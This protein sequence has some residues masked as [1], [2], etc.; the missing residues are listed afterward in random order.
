MFIR[1]DNKPT[2]RGADTSSMRSHNSRLLLKMLWRAGELS[3]ADLARGSG[4]SRSTVSAIVAEL[5][6]AGIVSES[7]VARSQGG[8]P[9][10]VL[11]IEA[12]RFFI[13]GLELGAS[14]ITALRVDLRGRVRHQASVS[15]DVEQD[16]DGAQA[17]LLQLTDEMVASAGEAA[18]VGIGL[19]VPCPVDPRRP[20]LLSPRIL[21]KWTDV[22]LGALLHHRYSAPVLVD[23]DANLGA[24]A[25]RWWGAGQ[26]SDDFSYVKV[27]TG[28]GAGHI[29]DGHVYR[30]AFGIA[31]EI[32]HTAIDPNGPSCRCGRSGCLETMIGSA[33]LVAR[34][35]ARVAAGEPSSLARAPITMDALLAAAREG[36]PL[37]ADIVGRAGHFLGIA[38]ANLV[39]LLNPSLI[40]LGGHLTEAG[41][42]VLDPLHRVLAERVL[43]SSMEVAAVEISTMGRTAVALGAATAVLQAALDEPTIFPKPGDA[44]A[45]TRLAARPQ[46]HALYS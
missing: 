27:A 23:N 31:G 41:S 43:G 2:D 29:F 7:H 19:A 46:D 42:L 22:R 16:P 37:A 44:A 5:L 8:R 30:G 14:H 10:I 18:L 3:R 38:V 24:V 21:P 39:N 28:V 4:L 33:S 25:E 1:S 20:D 11:R 34:A 17:A 13:L 40:V 26:H 32:G 36:D 15:H 45:P 12:E 35:R 6:D 9:P